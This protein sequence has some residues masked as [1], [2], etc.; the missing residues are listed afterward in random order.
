MNTNT[1]LK[2]SYPEVV[3]P[4]PKMVERLFLIEKELLELGIDLSPDFT[5]PSL[6]DTFLEKPVDKGQ[7][8][9]NLVGFNR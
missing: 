6:S 2:A 7:R 1:V 9:S 4:E 8:V 5:V 3:E